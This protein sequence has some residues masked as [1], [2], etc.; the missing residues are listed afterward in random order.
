MSSDFEDTFSNAN[1]YEAYV[2]RWSRFV[3]EQFVAWL[4]V[5]S[6][7]AWLD[8][9]VGTGVLTQVILQNASPARVVGVDL[10]PE[11][12]EFARQRIRD[13]RVAFRVGDAVTVPLES[14][15]F[16]VAVAGLVLNFLPAPEQA[17]KSM[18]Q[19]VR[20]GG[21]VAAY[22]WD[23]SGQMEMMRH[24]WDVA[25]KITPLQRKWTPVSDSR[26]AIQTACAPYSRWRI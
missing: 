14:T 24:F 23:Y 16:D 12:V 22:V 13:A 5:A 6:G 26:F 11:Y 3:A 10:S 21:L 25:L 15:A 2:G 1:S 20:N 17:V 7:Q 4:N 18:T 9:G 19:A 8:V